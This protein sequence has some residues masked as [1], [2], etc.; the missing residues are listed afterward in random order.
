M[1]P[2]Y[3]S[4][5]MGRSFRGKDHVF[6]QDNMHGSILEQ[7]T[8]HGG[9]GEVH[10]VWDMYEEAATL[11]N[12]GGLILLGGFDVDPAFY[13][14]AVGEEGYGGGWGTSKVDAYELQLIEDAIYRGLPIFGICR[15]MQL[16]NV[17][18]NGTLHNDISHIQG[19]KHHNFSAPVYGQRAV[20]HPVEISGSSIIPEGMYNVAS[21]HHQSADAV[22]ETLD[23]VGESP[24][25][26]VEMVE[27][28][29]YRAV[30]T[31]WHPESRHIPQDDTLTPVMNWFMN[32][33]AQVTAG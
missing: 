26:I 23:V 21:S 27:H 29:D 9:K 18:F 6:V 17:A 16:I 12:H 10:E 3:I 28:L 14:T 15:G 19:M 30:G 4:D 32:T 24:D 8:S 11:E 2:I 33:A 1:K 20:V 13:T 22:G 31:Q 25:G 5:P 7:I